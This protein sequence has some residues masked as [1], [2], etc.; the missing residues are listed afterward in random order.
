MGAGAQVT[1][2]APFEMK[3]YPEKYVF[4]SSKIFF[5]IYAYNNSEIKNKYT[6][7]NLRNRERNK[8]IYIKNRKIEKINLNKEIKKLDSHVPKLMKRLP[9][10]EKNGCWSK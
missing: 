9:Y 8:N 7:N 3:L 1:E 5:Y 10:L 4:F 2:I 6:Q